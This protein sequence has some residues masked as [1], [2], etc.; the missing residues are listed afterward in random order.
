MELNNYFSAVRAQ[1]LLIDPL[2]TLN[3]CF[4]LIIEEEKQKEIIVCSMSHEF[5]ALLTKFVL[6]PRSL[7][8]GE[9]IALMTK[10]TPGNRFAKP[11]FRKDRPICSHCGVFG[12]TIEKFFKV[13]EYP[14][15]F[16]FTR[17]KSPNQ[18][19]PTQY[20]G[21]Q[22][23]IQQPHPHHFNNP[24]SMS[25]PHQMSN[26]PQLSMIFAQCQHLM[27]MLT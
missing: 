3:I 20:S 23:H 22:V 10:S 13:H 27:D 17:N 5:A 16:K 25:N 26:P 6:N 14:P 9:P 1:I 12:H 21:N 24:L 15:E 4:L 11:N 19:S 2:S 8:I 7:Q 18:Y